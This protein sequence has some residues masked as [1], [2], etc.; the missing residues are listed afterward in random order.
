[1][2]AKERVEKVKFERVDAAAALPFNNDFSDHED[3]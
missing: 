1:M 3:A 2:H